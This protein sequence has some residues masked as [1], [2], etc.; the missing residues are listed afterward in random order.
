MAAEGRVVCRA[1][2]G[3]V[4]ATKSFHRLTQLGRKV[5]AAFRNVLNF[6]RGWFPALR[7]VKISSVYVIFLFL[8]RLV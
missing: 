8:S 2:Y 3:V 4:L 5:R 6:A 7:K 1:L